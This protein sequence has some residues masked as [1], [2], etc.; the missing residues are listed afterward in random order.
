MLL[1][2][3]KAAILDMDG[4]LWRGDTPIPGAGD[5]FAFLDARGT[6]FMLATN[7]STNTVA[8][9][10]EKLAG[11][12]FNVSPER[13]ITSSVATALYLQSRKP[14]ARVY[15]VGMFGLDQTLVD[16]GFTLVNANP[17]GADFVVAGLDRGLTY[18]K[19]KIASRL[20]RGGAVFV[21]TNPD[22]TFPTPEGPTPGAGT[23]LAAIEAPSGQ[24]PVVIGKPLPLMFELALKHLGVSAGEAVMIGDRLETDIL[25]GKR[26]GMYTVLVCTGIHTRGDIEA[27]GIKPDRVFDDLPAL[28]DAW[29]AALP[30]S[31]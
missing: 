1:A 7:N 28:R 2:Q 12:G 27:M 23:I 25:G 5:F 29:R 19:I 13:I 21:G 10:V 15:T 6:P 17:D 18:E 30:V 11:F 8:Q 20:I 3:I 9:Y 4:V 22:L 26:A 16:Y 14:G 31:S 24:E